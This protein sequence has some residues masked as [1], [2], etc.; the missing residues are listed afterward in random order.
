M[1]NSRSGRNIDSAL[2]KKGFQRV[3]DGDHVRYR[4]YVPGN[5]NPLARTKISHGMQGHAIGTKLLSEMA[6]QIHLTKAQ[7]LELIDCTLDEATYK[8]ILRE[9]GF[10]Q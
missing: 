10:V 7:F 8:N 5:D 9:K 3:R 1:S 2:V 6:R 4:F